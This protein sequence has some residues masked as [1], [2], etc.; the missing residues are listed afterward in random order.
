MKRLRR[1]AELFIF[2][3]LVSLHTQALSTETGDGGQKHAKAKKEELSIA[4]I[5]MG[6]VS[7]LRESHKI[8]WIKIKTIMNNM[9]LQFFPPDLDFRSRDAAIVDDQN[10]AGSK[11]RHAA[12]KSFG[13]SK[14]TVEETAKSV[15]EVVGKAVRKTAEKVKES[16]SDEDEGEESKSEL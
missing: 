15:A 13:T 10:N 11:V 4:K 8:S 7:F 2:W 5:V 1:I 6:A 12:K 16:K 9:Q 14:V 3:V